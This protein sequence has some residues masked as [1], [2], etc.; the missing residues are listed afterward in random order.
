MAGIDENA[1]G[2]TT[3][4]A[5]AETR[6]QAAT[7]ADNDDTDAAAI[8]ACSTVVDAHRRLSASAAAVAL[9]PGA[10]VGRFLVVEP[11]GEGGMGTVF[12]AYDPDLD[13]KV[14]IKL[15]Q[16][17]SWGGDSSSQGRER[18]VREAR[19]MAKLSHPNVLTVHEVGTFGDEVFIAMEFAAGGTLTEWLAA[20]ERSW[21]EVL[22]VFLRAGRGLA[23]AHAESLIHRDFKPDN[24][25]LTKDG[26][27][28]VADFGLVGVGAVPR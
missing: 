17:E 14:A 10:R 3:E 12:A 24:C 2:E 16:S 4:P 9:L 5:P 15:L 26:R 18:L 7:G 27:V 25:L 23:A 11:L 19:A 28:R 6:D 1:S 22:D 8:G 13:R 20:Q 21:R